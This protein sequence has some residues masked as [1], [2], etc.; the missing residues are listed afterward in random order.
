MGLTWWLDPNW[1]KGR[2]YNLDDKKMQKFQTMPQLGLTE[3][4]A[5][6]VSL[7]LEIIL[8]RMVDCIWR[9]AV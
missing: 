3:G 8:F 7:G 5:A 6:Q 1:K 9:I 2:C 4:F